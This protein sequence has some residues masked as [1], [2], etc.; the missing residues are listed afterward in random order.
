MREIP[1]TPP[2][3]DA[4]LAARIEQALRPKPLTAT[5]RFWLLVNVEHRVER[6]RASRRYW[7]SLAPLSAVAT[8]ALILAL[9]RPSPTPTPALSKSPAT[10]FTDS[11]QEEILYAP[12]WIQ[13]DVGFVDDEVLPADYAVA[14][15][16][17][18]S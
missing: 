10:V 7:L 13:S 6:A 12:E 8:A 15:A 14:S 18:G 2:R 11:W 5:E 17:L 16:F 4:E 3:D 9:L 1:R